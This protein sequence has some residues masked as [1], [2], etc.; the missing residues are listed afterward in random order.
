MQHLKKKTG[1]VCLEWTPCVCVRSLLSCMGTYPRLQNAKEEEDK[2]QIHKVVHQTLK[3][4]RS[5]D[6]HAG[7]RYSGLDASA[8]HHIMHLNGQFCT[9]TYRSK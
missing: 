7:H 3:S 5:T 2:C 6:V 1:A 9:D 4:S 8:S